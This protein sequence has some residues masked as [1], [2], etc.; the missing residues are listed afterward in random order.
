[1]WQRN[2]VS[3]NR[4]H[5]SRWYEA[6]LL[7]QRVESFPI[8]FATDYKH[9]YQIERVDVV[10]INRFSFENWM[11]ITSNGNAIA[12]DCNG[13]QSSSL[14]YETK[15]RSCGSKMR[16]LV[17]FSLGLCLCWKKYINKLRFCVFCVAR[18]CLM[19]FS[20]RV[21]FRGRFINGTYS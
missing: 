20:F 19:L 1:M 6:N 3:A 18:F 2:E 17:C 21:L 8:F 14:S 10:W 7:N 4:F 11:S 16:W 12:L 15:Q 13:R 5:I 9:I